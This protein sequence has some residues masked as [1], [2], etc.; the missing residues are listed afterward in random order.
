MS[1]IVKNIPKDLNLSWEIKFWD[2]LK[3][4]FDN[5]FLNIDF[6]EIDD[7]KISQTMVNSI[8]SMKEEIKNNGL[9]NFTSLSS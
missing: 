9:K 4:L 6:K 7:K 5:N 8:K 3:V 2:L 1:L